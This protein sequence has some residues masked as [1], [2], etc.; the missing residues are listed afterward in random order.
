LPISGVQF[1]PE[2]VATEHGHTLV[3]AWV[4][5]LA[6]RRERQES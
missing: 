4:A 2:S 5:R 6:G 1:H 3:E